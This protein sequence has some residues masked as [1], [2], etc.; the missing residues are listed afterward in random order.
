MFEWV[1][2]TQGG[3][4]LYGYWM[5]LNYIKIVMANSKHKNICQNIVPL[6]ALKA[7]KTI[8]NDKFFSTGIWKA[9]NLAWKAIL[10]K[11]KT[12][13]GYGILIICMQYLPIACDFDD[14]KIHVV[15]C[16]MH[17]ISY[18][19]RLLLISAAFH[20]SKSLLH[21]QKKN[22]AIDYFHRNFLN[23]LTFQYV[24]MDD[25]L[26]I[27]QLVFPINFSYFTVEAIL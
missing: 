5:V 14:P 6:H 3:N 4:I 20:V 1:P 23:F 24:R 16:S 25:H 9:N 27:A 8:S 15:I 12:R 2:V 11:Q 21:C 19:Q 7:C 18:K 13:C 22:D 26:C 17:I 10:T